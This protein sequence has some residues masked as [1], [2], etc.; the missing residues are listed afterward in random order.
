MQPSE[1]ATVLS[2][3][4]RQETT[5]EQVRKVAEAENLPAKDGTINRARSRSAAA[6]R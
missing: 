6:E 5:E 1:L 3:A 4:F 2:S